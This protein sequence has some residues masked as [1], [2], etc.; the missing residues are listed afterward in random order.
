MRRLLLPLVVVA[1][2]AA[3]VVGLS[4]A[5]GDDAPEGARDTVSLE[6]QREAVAD[7]PSPL[8]ELYAEPPLQPSSRDDF[9][10]RLATLRGT[11][12]VINK[13]GSWCGPCRLEFPVFQQAVQALGDRVAFL[14]LDGKDNRENAEEFLGEMPVAYPSFEDPDERIATDLDAVA[15]YPMTVFIDRGGDRHVHAGPYESLADLRAD[16]E[17]FALR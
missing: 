1:V 13:W 10:A 6:A 11:P 7:A 12:V 4:Q 2:A 3:V 17:R 16:I 9:R 8:K 14:G 5:G 15:L